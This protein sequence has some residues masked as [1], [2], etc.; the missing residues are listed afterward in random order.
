MWRVD[1]LNQ[2]VIVRDEDLE[3][4][5]DAARLRGLRP[6]VA[7]ENCGALA[8]EL[9]TL[10]ERRMQGKR[11]EPFGRLDGA[12]RAIATL[13]RPPLGCPDSG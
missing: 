6:R 5:E 9:Q 3:A 8:H 10:E 12:Q 13:M 4:F 7:D 2:R 1:G 11:Y